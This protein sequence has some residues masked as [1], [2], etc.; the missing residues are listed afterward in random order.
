[1]PID[2][3]I[4]H[5]CLKG[6][7]SIKKS[8]KFE[9]KKMLSTILLRSVIEVLNLLKPTVDE[10]RMQC[11]LEIIGKKCLETRFSANYAFRARQGTT[12]V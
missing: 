12:C 9:I 8:I 5:N 10:Y 11:T 2:I 4:G 3:G 1:M 7:A 6:L